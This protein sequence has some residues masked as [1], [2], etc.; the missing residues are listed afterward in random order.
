M[1][2][3]YIFK[4][5]DLLRTAMTHPSFNKQYKSSDFQRF[6]FFGDKIISMIL[7]E[8][9]MEKFPDAN[10]AELS[11][12][13]S[14]LVNT[15]AL[16]ELALEL[17]LD[18]SIVTDS[19]TSPLKPKILEDAMEALIAAIYLDSGFENTRTIINQ[20]YA[21]K[22]IKTEKNSVRDPKSLLQE[23]A[24]KMGK[25][26]PEYKI[27]EQVGDAHN[28]TFTIAVVVEGIPEGIAR[29]S[30]KKEAQMLAAQNMLLTIENEFN[31]K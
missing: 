8:I 17:E 7:A 25:P 12:M 14:N 4:N 9:L 10:E 26:I 28:P 18:K 23:W 6:E 2:I 22:V 5:K 21:D 16:A 3:D 1:K 19:G 20:L 27:I 30:S 31:E 15:K 29:G 24:Q 13:L 11:V